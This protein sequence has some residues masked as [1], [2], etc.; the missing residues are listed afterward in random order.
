M[1]YHWIDAF[2]KEDAQLK[3]N[4]A[5]IAVP[6]PEVANDLVT[7]FIDDS[8]SHSDEENFFLPEI[9][10]NNAATS[11]IDAM[12]KGQIALYCE[13]LYYQSLNMAEDPNADI[14]IG[15][16]VVSN[17]QEPFQETIKTTKMFQQEQQLKL[18]AVKYC[19]QD[20]QDF[21]NNDFSNI[22]KELLVGICVSNHINNPPT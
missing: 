13:T 14:L 19:R 8:E 22:E 10:K 9:I 17:Y 2:K 15:N 11:L 18:Q 7:D 1:K 6:K 3:S 16:C 12:T 21:S 20:I 5:E 4:V